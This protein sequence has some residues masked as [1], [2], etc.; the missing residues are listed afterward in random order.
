M[1]SLYPGAIGLQIWPSPSNAPVATVGPSCRIYGKVLNL[2][3]DPIG[4]TIARLVTTPDGSTV[5]SEWQGVSVT[6]R[7]S[8]A[9]KL[10]TNVIGTDSVT[11]ATDETGEFE[12]FVLQGLD[13][14]VS[15]QSLGKTLNIT[16][17][18]LD[19]VDISTLI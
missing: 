4:K 14:V 19:A 3:G 17:D 5:V 11:V 8:A 18:G 10:L 1:I 9:E 7:L 2:M 16:T 6:L 15:C 12:A 13:V